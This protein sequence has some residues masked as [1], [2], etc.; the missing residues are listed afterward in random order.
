[1][2]T[3]MTNHRG[4]AAEALWAELT[5]GLRRLWHGAGPVAIL[6]AS[7]TG[8]L[9]ALVTNALARGKRV[10]MASAG[11][12]GDRFGAVA[13][14]SGLVVD[15][16]RAEWGRALD[17][18][19]VARAVR[20]HRY[21]ALLLTQNETSTG[22]AHP[23]R[24]IV[25]AARPHVPLVFVDA[26][27]GCPAMPL[28]LDGWGID[29]VVLG[30]QKGLMLPPGLALIGLADRVAERFDGTPSVY[31][32][33]APYWRGN[34]PYTPALS[35]WYGLAESLA[36][37]E[38]EGEATRWRRHRTMS[39]MVRR[40]ARTLGFVPAAD[41]RWAS[42]TVTALRPPA[43]VEAPALLRAL[44]GLGVVMAGGQG[45]WRGQVIRVGHV[46]AVA[47]LDVVGAMAALERA[48]AALDGR[49]VT[50]AAAAAATAA[51]ATE[52]TGG[53]P[54]GTMEEIGGQRHG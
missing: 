22:V 24:E 33:L 12:F 49:P 20:R 36:L 43:G 41:E 29:A 7:G 44:R 5:A 6:P 42:P 54:A 31:W 30:S 15:W 28:E 8:G 47:P 40:A 4:Q 11:A 45:P 25:A 14:R 51:W 27:S 1:M 3:P 38:E 2:L 34:L 18:D 10:L 9:E 26:I 17:P 21:D 13:E 35:L 32:D 48:V 19:E 16:V 39:L 37:L 50:G 53:D 52:A 23:L 46:G